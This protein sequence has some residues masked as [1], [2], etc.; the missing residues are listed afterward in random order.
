MRHVRPCAGLA[1]GVAIGVCLHTGRAAADGPLTVRLTSPLGRTGTPGAV[2]IV[3]RVQAASSAVIGPVRFLIDGELYRTKDDGP[4]YVVE[5]VDENPFERREISVEVQDNAGHSAHDTVVLEPFE[6][7]DETDV[8][9]VVLDAA[10]R[11]K[12]GRF[13]TGLVPSHFAVIEEDVQQTPQLVGQESVPATFVLL[14]DSSQ[15][16]SRNYDFVRQA[17]RRLLQYLKPHDAAIVAPFS[18]TL[19]A[20]TGP[21]NDRETIISAIG[22]ASAAGGTAIFDS[23]HQMADRI[24][25]EPSRHA[26]ILITDGYDENSQETFSD[27]VEAVKRA[28]ATVYAVAIGGSAGVSY[29]GQQQLKELTAQTGGRFFVPIRPDDLSQVYD[30]LAADAQNRYVISYTPSNQAHDGTFRKVMVKAV[31]AQGDEYRVT[32]R[33][34][35]YA[36]KAPPVKPLLEFTVTDEHQELIDVTRDDLVVIEDGVEQ[37]IET[38]QIAVDPVQIVLTLDESGSMRRVVDT[39]KEAAREFVRTLEPKDPLALITFSDKV[40]F[41]HDLSTVREW[42]FDAIDK[43]QALGGTALYDALY[44]SIMRL[45]SVKGRKAVVILTDGR[46]ENNPG[47]APGSV[48][49]IDDV[50]ARLKEVDAA[51]YPIGLGSRVDAKMLEHLAEISGG[52]AYFPE[53]ATMLADQY[54]GIVENLRRRYVVGYASTNLK[55]DG[56]WRI[57]EIKPKEGTLQVR[58]RGGYFAP[59]R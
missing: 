10:V 37:E 19:G 24:A 7:T 53:D 43:Y 56:A 35:Y 5:W 18:K 57:V 40:S 30:Q 12:T 6:L 38:F 55:R 50:L 58:S 8:F 59:E 32:T 47:T 51:I 29:R 9:S 54:R 45:K 11:D 14:V 20:I 27:A 1:L 36:P 39:V 25:L 15:S 33:D 41:A 46:D 48:H 26:I 13:I 4:P 16:M 49:V 42:S 31:T 52:R 17:A 21:T 3:A 22:A 44:N 28:R 23:L 34:G 2:R